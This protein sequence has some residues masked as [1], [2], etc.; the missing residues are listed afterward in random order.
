MS[1]YVKIWTSTLNDEWFTSLS[2]V[3]RGI[4]LQLLIYAKSAGDTG[5]IST[6]N[7]GVLAGI[8][9]ADT[10]TLRKSLGFFAE[11]SHI[12]ILSHKSPLTLRICK[13]KYWQGLRKWSD[14]L[15]DRKILEK[16]LLSRAEQNKEDHQKSQWSGFQPTQ[17]RE[18]KIEF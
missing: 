17:K 15:D 9:G 3:R 14:H 6:K 10:E 4:W 12:E 8:L 13:Y 5:E 16:S 18:P 2:C 7:P 1:G 11:K